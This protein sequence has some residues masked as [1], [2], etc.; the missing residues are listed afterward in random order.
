M[1]YGWPVTIDEGSVELR[2][3]RHRDEG[4]WHDL[5]ARNV[6]WLQRW[7]ATA[8]DGTGAPMR[9]S[10]LVRHYRAEGRAGRMLPWVI[11][12]DDQLVGQLT[13]G[14][15]QWGSLRCAQMGYWI[16]QEYAGRGTVPTAVAMAT[17]YCLGTLGLHRMEINIRPENDASLRVVDK[18]GFR[19][20]GMRLK[21]LHID[22]GWRDHRTFALTR[23][24]LATSLMSRWRASRHHLA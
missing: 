19:D 10:Q 1:V 5:R 22:G 17:D 6:A 2:P 12:V 11:T 23:E 14:S 8:P 9:F 15:I 7:E 16:G 20:E 21:Y 4:A 3:L 18:L 13:V 24:D